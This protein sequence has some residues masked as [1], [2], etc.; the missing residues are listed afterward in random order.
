MWTS[1]MMMGG[2]KRPIARIGSASANALGAAAVVSKPT[3]TKS[4]HL[5]IAFAGQNGATW[6]P[7][8]GWTEERDSSGLSVSWKIAGGSEPSTYSFTSSFTTGRVSIVTYSHAAID[9]V[10]T[11]GVPAPSITLSKNKS[12]LLAGFLA[13]SGILTPSGMTSVENGALGGTNLLVAEQ[14]LMSA[15]ATGTKSPAAGTPNA[16]VLVGL[17]PK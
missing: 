8:S 11:I 13:S 12:V 5:M 2:I 14:L 16:G 3:G 4:G 17:K 10:G 15:G 1:S 7:P 6:T 9:V